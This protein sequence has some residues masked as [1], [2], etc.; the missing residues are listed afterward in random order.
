MV[1]LVSCLTGDGSS[2]KPADNSGSAGTASNTNPP[3]QVPASTSTPGG[4]SH[5]GPNSAAGA[6]AP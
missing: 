1:Y 2:S 5:L 4:G 3:P 6:G